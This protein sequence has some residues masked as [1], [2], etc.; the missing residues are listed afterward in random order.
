MDSYYEWPTIRT[1]PL[2]GFIIA[3]CLPFVNTLFHNFFK[4]REDCSVDPAG[5]VFH[6]NSK[7]NAENWKT[8][9]E[10]HFDYLAFTF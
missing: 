3:D 1:A 4:S 6:G 2:D 8:D 7:H 5:C 10:T 9:E